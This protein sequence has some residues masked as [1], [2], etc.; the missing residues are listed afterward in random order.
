MISRLPII[1]AIAVSLFPT[2]GAAQCVVPDYQLPPSDSSQKTFELKL[3]YPD[4]RQDLDAFSTQTDFR[5]DWKEYLM[6][7]LAYSLDGHLETD[8]VVQN[9][10][11]REWFHTPWLHAGHAGREYKHGLT[12]ERTSQPEELQE[13]VAKYFQNWGVG[14]YNEVAASQLGKIWKDY[15]NPSLKALRELDFP[16]GSVSFKVLFTEASEAEIDA[17]AGA[18]KWTAHIHP[19]G[20]YP[21]RDPMHEKLNVCD[22]TESCPRELREVSLL[23]IDVAVKDKRAPDTGWVFGTFAY[24]HRVDAED[25]WSKLRPISIGWG[26]DPSVVDGS[27]LEENRINVDFYG[28]FYGWEER[29]HLGW[30]GRA[31]GP[32]DNPRSSCVACHGSAQFPRSDTFGNVLSSRSTLEPEQMNRVYFRNIESGQLFDPD[33]IPRFPFSS[34]MV[35]PLSLDYSLQTQLGLEQLCFS[36]IDNTHPFTAATAKPDI[37]PDK[38]EVSSSFQAEAFARPTAETLLIERMLGED[39]DFPVS[40]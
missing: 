10:E 18:P 26:N 28:V 8:F 21:E 20:V 17:L 35:V 23:Q 22:V 6:E 19:E 5:T 24:D 30:G 15:C 27:D 16:E 9:N 39:R 29:V 12:R 37:C 25:P 4:E 3:D 33:V 13:G 32:V 14:F 1:L 31:N 36:W 40:K 34:D 7:V 38:R 2:T 11:V